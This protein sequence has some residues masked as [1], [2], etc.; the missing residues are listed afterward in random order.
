MIITV[1]CYSDGRIIIRYKIS[2]VVVETL[3]K[4]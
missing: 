3:I 1:S 4:I 2:N